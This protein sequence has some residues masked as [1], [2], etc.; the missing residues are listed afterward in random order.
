MYEDAGRPPATRGKTSRAGAIFT[1]KDDPRVEPVG[2]FLRRCRST[3]AAL[4]NVLKHE[5]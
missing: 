2:R 5:M 3:A 1:I 4:I